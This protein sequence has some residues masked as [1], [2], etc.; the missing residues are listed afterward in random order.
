M[1]IIR[2]QLA[3]YRATELSNLL[4]DFSTSARDSGFSFITDLRSEVLA[5]VQIL[6]SQGV[7]SY[8]LA[9]GNYQLS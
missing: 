6:K 9:D 8:E 2:I 5:L 3:Y 1:Y 4:F 7:V